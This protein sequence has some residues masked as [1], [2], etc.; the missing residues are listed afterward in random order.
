MGAAPGRPAVAS[1]QD[2][3]DAAVADGALVA[4]GG[5]ELRRKPVAAARELEFKHLRA[6]ASERRAHA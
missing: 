2:T 5:G 3:L 1:L 4:F 6:A